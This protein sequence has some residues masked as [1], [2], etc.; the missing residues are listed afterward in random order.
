MAIRFGFRWIPFVAA[1]L[2]IA[3]GVAL[4]QWQM[5]RAAS[6]Q[7]IELKLNARESASPLTLGAAPLAIDDVEYRR[8]QVIGEFV[9]D[10]P[11]YLDNRPHLGVAGFYVLMPFRIAGSD[12]HVL[13]VRGWLPRDPANRS[14]LAP[15]ATPS[16]QLQLQGVARR[17]P[18]H[19]LQLGQPEQLRPGAIVQNLA[20]AEF[21]QASGL[22]MQPL[23]IEQTSVVPDG[24][25]RDWPRPSSGIDKH[26]GYAF[27][28]YALAA[29]AFL[30]FL[31]TGF[32][33]GTK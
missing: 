10:W 20:V 29:M 24:L 23:L 14:K 25:V 17:N 6:K 3:L 31:V 18:G 11:V 8:V 15:I 12:M 19:V 28:W 21:A 1:L 7:A 4:G 16:G 13:V 32:R 22:R 5:R 33:R 26:L 2:A 30:F 27:Q 9:G